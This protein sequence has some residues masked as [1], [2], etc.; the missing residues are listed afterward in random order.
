M[1]ALCSVRAS[2]RYSLRD[3]HVVEPRRCEDGVRPIFSSEFRKSS[4]LQG[5]AGSFGGKGGGARDAKGWFGT[6]EAPSKPARL[7]VITAVI[8]K[9]DGR[10][11]AARPNAHRG[12]GAIREA[13][14]MVSL[15]DWTPDRALS[16]RW[17]NAGLRFRPR[18]SAVFPS[19]PAGPVWRCRCRPARSW[20]CFA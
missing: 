11:G 3:D 17:Y 13:C 8:E 7:C 4:H 10:W 2:R 16:H 1:R 19:V 18:R 6:N 15:W 20:G 14:C 9:D 12:R 5:C